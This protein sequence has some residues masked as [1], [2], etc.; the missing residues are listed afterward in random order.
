MILKENSIISL[1]NS[2]FERLSGYSKEEIENKM[3]WTAFVIPEDLEK[4]KRYYAA[5]RKVG[6]KEPNRPAKGIGT[7]LEEISKNKGILYEP[8][9]VDS[10]LL[11]FKEEKYRF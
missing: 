9:V 5:R 10:Y 1:S 8:K 11:L 2:Q 6:G 7:P 4:M 3:K